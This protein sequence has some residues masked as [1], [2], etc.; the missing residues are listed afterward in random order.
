MAIVTRPVKD[1][2]V[3]YHTK[4]IKYKPEFRY[5][6]FK[7]PAMDL[8]YVINKADKY[9]EVDVAGK[10]FN[11]SEQNASNA[12]SKYIECTIVDA[13]NCERSLKSFEDQLI[14]K[15]KDNSTC[16]L[17]GFEVVLDSN[18]RKVILT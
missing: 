2:F 9:D 5:N 1:V 17:T 13:T 16:K 18:Q 11:F 10:L 4:V 3:R 14:G 15:G 12:R 8:E 7:K 6:E